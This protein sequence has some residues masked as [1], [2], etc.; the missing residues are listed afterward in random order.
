MQ[1]PF[2]RRLAPKVL[3]ALAG[4]AACA[5]M[6]ETIWA[7]QHAEAAAAD[8]VVP[9][10]PVETTVLASR[11]TDL[12]RSGIGTVQAW[13]SALITPQVS[14]QI[15]EL[16]FREGTPV[17]AGDVLVR[18]DPRSFQAALDQAISR[19]DQDLANLAGT[20][21]NLVRDETLVAK[22]GFASQQTVDNEQAQVD[23]LKASIAGDAAAIE[24]AR[25]NLDYTTIRAPFSGV[26][27]LRNV[28][29][30]NVVSP[31]T[32]ILTLAQIEP[33]AVD[34]T[35]PQA[36]LAVV[37]AAL[38]GG[39]PAVTAYD[40]DGTTPIATGS[41]E[42]LNNQ[43]DPTTGTIK[44]KARFENADGLLW[45]GAFVEMRIVVKRETNAL[46]L[47]SQAV[48]H[49]PSGTYVWRVAGDAVR[50]SPVEIEASQDDSVVIGKGLAAGDRIVVSGQYRLDEGSRVSESDPSKVAQAPEAQS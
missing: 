29:L 2:L 21:K 27:G 46:V 47:P 36:D 40:Q 20:Q 34:F 25:I 5:G 28:D 31:G 33:I 48:Q 16:P 23:A 39:E 3:I 19:R 7:R 49:G 11:S 41:V 9:P 8:P 30:G 42:V 22:G 12:V 15:V 6:G 18:I 14:G 44:L 50:M 17:K 24:T 4:A 13:N 38:K 1:R 26:P 32:N 10:V 37:K 43:L 45:P 35:L